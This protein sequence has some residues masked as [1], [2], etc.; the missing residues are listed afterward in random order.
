[1]PALLEKLNTSVGNSRKFE[2]AIKIGGLS[3][4]KIGGLSAIKIGGLS[5][6]K[7]ADKSK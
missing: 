7:M 4:I 6:T 1:L 3:A 2:S 5:A